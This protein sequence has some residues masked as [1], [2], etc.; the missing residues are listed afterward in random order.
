MNMVSTTLLRLLL[1]AAASATVQAGH[2]AQGWKAGKFKTLVT[3]GD[4]YT[5]E[6]RLGYFIQSNGTAPP[7]GWDQPV[8]GTLLR[9]WSTVLTATGFGNSLR[10]SVLGPICQHLLYSKTLQL[11]CV[12]RCML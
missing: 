1:A 11:R 5:D 9:A 4:S 6:N 3:F 8:V 7:V 2:P 10:W 12:G